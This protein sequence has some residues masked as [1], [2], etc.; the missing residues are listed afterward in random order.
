MTCGKLNPQIYPK[1]ND[2]FFPFYFH[3]FCLYQLPY[4]KVR[5]LRF[6]SFLVPHLPQ[7][8]VLSVP[9]SKYLKELISLPYMLS[10][11]ICQALTNSLLFWSYLTKSVQLP[12]KPFQNTNLASPYPPEHNL[13]LPSGFSDKVQPRQ[14]TKPSMTRSCLPLVSHLL[15][16][17]S[18]GWHQSVCRPCRHHLHGSC[19]LCSAHLSSPVQLCSGLSSCRQSSSAPRQAQVPLSYSPNIARK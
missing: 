15:P 7:I 13:Y 10:S 16:P 4:F 2:F 19:S 3:F 6:N 14:P 8:S 12:E 11:S 18:S 9:L 1:W 5:N 17:I